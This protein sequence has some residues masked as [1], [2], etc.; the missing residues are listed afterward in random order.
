MSDAL[1]KV[2]LLV[3]FFSSALFLSSCVSIEQ[4]PIPVIYLL[5]YNS[6]L[7]L[8]SFSKQSLSNPLCLLQLSLSTLPPS[9]PPSPPTHT[10]TLSL[11]LSL[12]LALYLSLS[13][14]LLFFPFSFIC[15][16]M[17]ASQNQCLRD[18]AKSHPFYQRLAGKHTPQTRVPTTAEIYVSS[19]NPNS[20]HSS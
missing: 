8:P 15:I 17:N 9:F 14:S 5:S 13:L 12:S 1:T 7:F 10:H 18:Q 6:P 20:Q 16:S 19:L 11:S 3:H 4:F 2:S